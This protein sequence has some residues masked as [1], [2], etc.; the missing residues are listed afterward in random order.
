VS[1]KSFVIGTKG[2]GDQSEANQIAANLLQIG[3]QLL[4]VSTGKKRVTAH[5]ITMGGA[6]DWPLQDPAS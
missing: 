3:T 4:P 5:T 2:I 1:K 6:S